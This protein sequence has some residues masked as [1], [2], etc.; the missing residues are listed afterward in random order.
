MCAYVN[1][2]MLEDIICLYDMNVYVGIMFVCMCMYVCTLLISDCT[3]I[4][5]YAH[6]GMCLCRPLHNY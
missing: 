2:Y 6:T 4:A 1:M 3:V 5:V